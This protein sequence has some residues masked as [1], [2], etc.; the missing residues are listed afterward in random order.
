MANIFSSLLSG[1][2]SLGGLGNLIG[3]IGTAIGGAS[4]VLNKQKPRDNPSYA[5]QQYL[6]Q[7]PGTI[8]PYFRPYIE[9]GQQ[10]LPSLGNTFTELITDPAATYSRLSQGYQASPGYK[11][12]LQEALKSAENASAAGGTLGT[13]LHQETAA[14]I[15]ERIAG[16]DFENYLNHLLGLYGGGLTGEERIVNRGYESGSRLAEN[17]GS[18]LGTQA[19]YGYT[20][21]AGEQQS[22]AQNWANLVGGLSQAA[23]YLFNSRNTNAGSNA[24]NKVGSAPFQF[25]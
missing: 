24:A 25:S 7:I 9:Q 10:Y 16:E 4:G 18:L 17:L 22:K 13:P 5:A 2:G 14:R 3:G 23:P 19:G 8:T 21:K 6:N 1:L 12:R 11:L 15:G 20:G